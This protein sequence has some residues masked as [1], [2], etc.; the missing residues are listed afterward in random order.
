[1]ANKKR[2]SNKEFLG[3][4]REYLPSE[5][6]AREINADGKAGERVRPWDLG[7]NT[8]YLFDAET[9]SAIGNAIEDL[10]LEEADGS[11]LACF[12]Q[13]KNF[14]VHRERYSH[15]ATTID[16]VEVL[17][18]GKAPARIRRLKFVED[19]RG[20][21]KNFWGVLY[22]GRRREALLIC[23]QANQAK[24]FDEKT[25]L[26]FYTFNPWLLNRI[27]QEILDLVQGRASSLPEFQRQQG[28]D[29]AA[30]HIRLEFTREKEALGRAVSRFEVD[31]DRY[32]VS[33]FMSDLEQGLL[34]LRQCKT[35]MPEIIARAEGPARP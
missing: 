19:G 35:R 16:R 28:I 15:L 5:A 4:V 18:G 21:C 24:T 29:V 9:M 3:S 14:E 2:F 17:A 11:L 30:K 23:Q 8:F 25:F 32:R 20:A 27:R 6:V 1:M 26:G 7:E 12:Q 33:H 22:E 31:S 13:F 10:A 34:R